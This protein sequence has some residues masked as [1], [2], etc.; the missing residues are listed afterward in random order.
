MITG[1]KQETAINIAISCKLIQSPDGAMMCNAP[2]SP[3]QAMARLAELL[4]RTE[5]RMLAAAN[6]QRGLGDDDVRTPLILCSE[7]VRDCS[8]R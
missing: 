2:A 5:E 8:R 4:Q 3:E 6:Q 1:D 7:S